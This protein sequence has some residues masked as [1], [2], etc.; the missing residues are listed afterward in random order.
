MQ[1]EPQ[2]WMASYHS[3]FSL[4]WCPVGCRMKGKNCTHC[5]HSM[6][7][8]EG[9]WETTF[10]C[11]LFVYPTISIKP[12]DRGRVVNTGKAPRSTLWQISIGGY[13]KLKIFLPYQKVQ[14]GQG[15]VSVIHLC[16][17]I[18]YLANIISN[19]IYG[20]IN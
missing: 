15:C 14:G 3:S 5:I 19:V 13:L 9:R 1:N 20:W 8:V 17:Q 6:I 4:M 7:Q 12:A 16:A 11:D 2:I 18:Q 10:S